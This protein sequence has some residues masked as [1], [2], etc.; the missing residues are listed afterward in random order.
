M[1]VLLTFHTYYMLPLPIPSLFLSL[2]HAMTHSHSHN[3]EL[4]TFPVGL[5]S[6]TVCILCFVIIIVTILGNAL[7]LLT[8]TT[9]KLLHTTT[10]FMIVSLSVADI[11]VALTVMPIR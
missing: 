5:V 10:N 3:L 4:A 9:K 2:T 7:V 11:M 8:I 1:V 6:I